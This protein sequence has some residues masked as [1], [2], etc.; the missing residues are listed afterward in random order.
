MK[1]YRTGVE[2]GSKTQDDHCEWNKDLLRYAVIPKNNKLPNRRVERNSHHNYIY[3]LKSWLNTTG[4][5]VT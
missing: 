3:W 4:A 5:G 1:S 2:V